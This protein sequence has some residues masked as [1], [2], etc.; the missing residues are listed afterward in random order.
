MLDF[1]G[2]GSGGRCNTGQAPIKIHQRGMAGAMHRAGGPVKCT[3]PV[4]SK[5]AHAADG[6]NGRGAV[7]VVDLLT[8]LVELRV[9]GC[10]QP[11]S[12]GLARTIP[13]SCFSCST[14]RPPSP[15][16][17]CDVFRLLAL[18]PWCSPSCQRG[19]CFRRATGSTS[20]GGARLV[21]IG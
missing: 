12:G 16:M 11:S 9:L 17:F 6:N 4:Q 5:P 18:T 14:C 10:E 21:G 15:C 3:G 2:P 1:V 19:R 13:F 7:A 20:Y 8:R